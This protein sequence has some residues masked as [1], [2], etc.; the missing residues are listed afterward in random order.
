LE[1]VPTET[2]IAKQKLNEKDKSVIKVSG[3][4][5]EGNFVTSVTVET[6]NDG[7]TYNQVSRGKEFEVA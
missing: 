6:S 5:L 2:D 7:R 3:I 1:I 4:I